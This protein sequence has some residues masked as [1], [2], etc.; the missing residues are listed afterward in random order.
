L[1]GDGVVDVVLNV[2]VED[3]DTIL[4]LTAVARDVD[5]VLT[6]VSEELLTVV[7]FNT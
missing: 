5:E 4:E 3:I 2:E 7:P 1:V 6:D